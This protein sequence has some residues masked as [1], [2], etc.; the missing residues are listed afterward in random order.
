MLDSL[1]IASTG[2]NAQQTQIDVISNNIANVNTAAYKKSKINFSDIFYNEMSVNQSQNNQAL[3]LDS[4]GAGVAASA[5]EKVFTD[6][7]LKKTNSELDIAITGNGFY[8]IMLKD[9]TSAYTRTGTFKLDK[10]GFLVDK[11]GNYL[12]SMVQIPSDAENIIIA[13]NGVVSVRLPNENTPIEV[14]QIDLALFVNPGS[15]QSNGNNMYLATEDSGDP[16]YSKPGESGIGVL[17]QGY[18]ES[19]NV[20]YIEEL[21]GLV[22]AQ[23]AFE[24]NSKMIQASDQILG[25]INNLYRS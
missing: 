6:G 12:S 20:D 13:S 25:I 21:T 3:R 15:L 7:S 5:K 16:V 2:L 11:D 14:G 8:E 4:T 18:V 9:G 17:S 23:R 10:D 19:S 24:M 1:Y 22:L